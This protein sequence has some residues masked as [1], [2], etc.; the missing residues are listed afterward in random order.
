[1][2]FINM[3]L[4]AVLL[5]CS[6]LALAKDPMRIAVLDQFGALLETTEAQKLLESY[7]AEAEADRGKILAIEDEMKK[8]DAKLAKEADVMSATEASNLRSSM[9]DKQLDRNVLIKKLQNKNQEAQK[10]I[11]AAVGPKLEKILK[12]MTDE[13][14][15][16]MILQR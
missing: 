8:A 9:Q 6:S 13:G 10:Q 4:V 11:L 14:D 15:Y 12:E 16:D 1:M 3:C 2:R 5:M 7:K